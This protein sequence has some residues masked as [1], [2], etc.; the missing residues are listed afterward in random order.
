MLQEGVKRQKRAYPRWREDQRQID[1]LPPAVS[2]QDRDSYGYWPINRLGLPEHM[3]DARG[4]RAAGQ[5][6]RSHHDSL[7]M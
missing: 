4:C 7:E 3:G 2:E 5:P 6:I 1:G